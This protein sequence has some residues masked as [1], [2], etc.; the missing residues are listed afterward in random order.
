MLHEIPGLW[1]QA[2]ALLP[3]L[4]RQYVH[5]LIETHSS[6][7]ER[8]VA[9]RQM[10]RAPEL[11]VVAVFGLIAADLL[12]RRMG[13]GWG[14][15]LQKPS[16]HAARRLLRHKA[17]AIR[18]SQGGA[19]D[20]STHAIA[21][22]ILGVVGTSR[23]HLII[24]QLAQNE[25]PIVRLE[26]ICACSQESTLDSNVLLK[27]AQKDP[28]RDV[29]FA[30][31]SALAGR[32]E[33]AL[34]RQIVED[35]SDARWYAAAELARDVKEFPNLQRILSA[36]RLPADADARIAGFYDDLV[37]AGICKIYR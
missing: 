22:R 25:D 11:E 30:A 4:A 6:T 29:R 35:D 32:G 2:V 3:P 7:E 36:L 34:L 21:I 28:V 17:I 27:S 24:S 31:V 14:G 23:D 12:T 18:Q 15:R 1:K 13:D 5:I 33:I 8:A 19:P 37:R 20:C 16:R 26:A 9:A 10:A